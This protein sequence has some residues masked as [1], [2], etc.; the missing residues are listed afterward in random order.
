MPIATSQPELVPMQ[1]RRTFFISRCAGRSLLCSG[2]FRGEGIYKLVYSM[3]VSAM[4][5]CLHSSSEG[6]AKCEMETVF[7]YLMCRQ[8]R[9][10]FAAAAELCLQF[11]LLRQDI[12]AEKS[13]LY[14]LATG[15]ELHGVVEACMQSFSME[16]RQFYF[17]RQ[18][19]PARELFLRICNYHNGY[20]VLLQH[21]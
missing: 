2:L 9:C 16:T 4:F 7:Y 14:A 19:S 21:G 6:V 1:M 3:R 15:S 5:D 13:L 8:S 17:A 11:C 12:Q 10:L 18:A 20:A